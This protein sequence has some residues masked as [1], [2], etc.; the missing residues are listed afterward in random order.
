MR[1]IGVGEENANVISTAISEYIHTLGDEAWL[2]G[3]FIL[4]CGNNSVDS[5]VLGIVHNN[6][7]MGRRIDASDKVKLYSMST[8]TGINIQVKNVSFDKCLD[9]SE[10]RSYELPIK[11]MIKSGYIIYD[12]KGNLKTLQRQ[13][14]N[15]ASIEGLEGRGAVHMEPAVQ[16]K[17]E[18]NL[19]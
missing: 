17:K 13:Y 6:W 18:M 3:A 2:E 1:K 14:K 4:P 12:V 5:L 16:Y 15:D 7:R 8:C 19:Y 10:Y 9:F 11:S